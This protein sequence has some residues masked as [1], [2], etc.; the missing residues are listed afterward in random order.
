MLSRQHFKNEFIFLYG[1]I[2]DLYS[3]IIIIIS[4]SDRART[5]VRND[6][7]NDGKNIHILYYGDFD[8]SGDYMVGD[9]IGR[10]SQ[11]GLTSDKIDFQ[12]IAVT[13][14][15]IK[16][17]NLPSNPDKITAEKMNRDSRTIGF[18]EK[19]G[20]LYAVELDALPALIPEVFS[21]LV[22]QSVEQFFDME[23]YT[24]I[25]SNNSSNEIKELLKNKIIQL[26]K[27]L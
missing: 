14:E 20:R 13:L 19:Y 21:K 10:M 25:I 16:K 11:L 23:I 27:E 2:F 4:W 9:L 15:Q 3:S 8:P 6:D 24:E 7:D 5:S 17:Y 22:I 1:K 26:S 12:K 18:V